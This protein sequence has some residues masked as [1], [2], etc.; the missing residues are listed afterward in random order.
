MRPGF[1][2]VRRAILTPFLETFSDKIGIL[3]GDADDAWLTPWHSVA[4]KLPTG[5]RWMPRQK[6]EELGAQRAAIRDRL[7]YYDLTERP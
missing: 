4:V 7:Y 2:I 1:E 5:F 3:L 6:A